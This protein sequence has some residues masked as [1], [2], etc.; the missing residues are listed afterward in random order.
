MTRKSPIAAI[1]GLGFSEMSRSYVGSS[2]QLAV[3]AVRTAVGDAGLKKDQIDGL[4][5]N[6]SPV[7]PSE[8]LDLKLQDE[9][10]LRD[11]KLLSLIDAEGSSAAQMIQYAALAVHA[12]MATHVACVFA[13][14]PLMPGVS[15]GDA[16]AITTNLFCMPG[17]EAHYGLFGAI[18]PY[19]LSCRRHMARFGTTEQHLG[20]VALSSRAW[21]QKNPKAFLRKSLTMEA[22]LASPWI[23]EPFRLLDCAYPVNGAVAVVV[24]RHD[25][26]PG[27]QPGVFIHGMGQGHAGNPN[28]SGFEPEV[29]TGARIAGEGAYAMAGIS[30]QD[31]DQVQL[32]DAFTYTCIVKLEDYGFCKKGEGGPFVADGHTAPGG[33][34]PMNTSGGQLSGYYL[35]GMTPI[36]EAVIQARGHGGERQVKNDLVFV[37]G[38]GGRM[39][40]HTCFVLSPHPSL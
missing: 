33:S 10:G 27:A 24:S 12:G 1:T 17:Q 39:E 34:L 16:F 20:S 14:V 2:R 15:A 25:H 30:P 28:R 36:S 11:L 37:C 21:A 19:G 8:T 4:L 35:Q 31:I 23:A 9:L 22:Y 26:A 32:Y 5:I 3:N 38:N 7:A 13:D 6:R 18:G 29:M 40:Y